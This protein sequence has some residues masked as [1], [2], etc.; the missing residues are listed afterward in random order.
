VAAVA[1]AA[2]GVGVEGVAGAWGDQRRQPRAAESASPPPLIS[3]RLESAADAAAAAA[4]AATSTFNPAV[5]SQRC[6]AAKGAVIDAAAPR[7]PRIHPGAPLV[8][9]TRKED[10]MEPEAK[11]EDERRSSTP[12]PEVSSFLRHRVRA[13]AFYIVPRAR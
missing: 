4:A 1:A 6:A 11:E 2:A 13:N 9:E 7:P 8:A 12:S 10:A 5:A 3:R